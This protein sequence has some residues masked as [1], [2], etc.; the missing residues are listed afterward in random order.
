ME[1]LGRDQLLEWIST[2][3]QQQVDSLEA[4][5][6]G[7]LFLQVLDH[8]VP[9]A[10]LDQARMVS[11]PTTKREVLRNYSL[12][13]E[14]LSGST[15]LQGFSDLC[16]RGEV[17]GK[18]DCLQF[19]ALLYRHCQHVTRIKSGLANLKM[20]RRP[21]ARREAPEKRSPQEAPPVSPARSPR[22][23]VRL[24]TSP[25]ALGVHSWAPPTPTKACMSPA[26]QI[27][28]RMG[29][30]TDS[31]LS[32]GAQC[33]VHGLGPSEAEVAVL[34]ALCRGFLSRS[35][36]EKRLAIQEYGATAVQSVWRGHAVRQ[37]ARAARVRIAGKQ[38]QLAMLRA[39]EEQFA[40][41]QVQ[42]AREARAAQEE[43]SLRAEEAAVAAQEAR[44]QAA[45]QEAAEE[46]AAAAERDAVEAAAAATE[47]AAEEAAAQA[48]TAER[49][50]AQAV[51]EEAA[52]Q[53][54]AAEA[55]QAAEEAAAAEAA[56]AQ[57]AA[58]EAAAEEATRAQAAAEE[59]AAEEA[60]RAQAA[61]EEAAAE[62]AAQKAH[63]QA[64]AEEAAA[65]AAAQKAHAQ[66][67]AEEAAAEAA[68][69]KAQAQAAAEE[70]AAEAAAQKAQAQAAAEEA[71]AEAAAQKAQAQAA[72][73]EA[74]A[75][76][77]AA[78]AA[79]RTQAAAAEEAR[80]Q[81][82]AASALAAAEDTARAQARLRSKAVQLLSRALTRAQASAAMRHAF[83][84]YLVQWS[85]CRHKSSQLR[86]KATQ[87][88]NA[89]CF[90]RVQVHQLEALSCFK[91]NHASQGRSR[92]LEQAEKKRQ[93]HET[94]LGVHI[95]GP[96][97]QGLPQPA[98]SPAQSIRKHRQHGLDGSS[99]N[100]ANWRWSDDEASGYWPEFQTGQSVAEHISGRS[101]TKAAEPV[102]QS[103]L[104]AFFADE[105]ADDGSVPEVA[106]SPAQK[107]R[108]K[109]E[110]HPTNWPGSALAVEGNSSHSHS[111]HSSRP[112]TAQ[113]E[114]SYEA[115]SSP[116]LRTRQSGEHSRH[117]SRPGTAQGEQSYEAPS[118]PNLRT[119]QSGEH[120]RHS[121]RPGT[122]Q[123]E[124]S[125]EAPSSPNLRTR[126]SG[127][128]SRHSSRPGTAQGEQS[129]EAPAS[130]ADRIKAS[131][132]WQ[133][134]GAYDSDRYASKKQEEQAL[135][136]QLHPEFSAP[137]QL[138]HLTAAPRRRLMTPDLELQLQ[139]ID[140]RKLT[141]AAPLSSTD[142]LT[143]ALLL[144][145]QQIIQNE[146]DE[147]SSVME[148]RRQLGNMALQQLLN[149]GS[150]AG[151]LQASPAPTVQPPVS[152]SRLQP[153]QPRLQ[154]A[155][156]AR[157]VTNRST[158]D[159]FDIARTND[160]DLEPAAHN[161]S[162]VVE[163]SVISIPMDTVH[164]REP[165]LNSARK[166]ATDRPTECEAR[167]PPV[168][169]GSLDRSN[170][171][172]IRNALQHVCL[173]GPVKKPEL[174]DALGVLDARGNV[175]HYMVLFASDKNL[176]FRGLYELDAGMDVATKVHGVGP[177]TVQAGK[178]YKFFNYSS[179]SKSFGT[180]PTTT[181]GYTV[182]GFALA[183]SMRNK[184]TRPS[185]QNSK[186]KTMV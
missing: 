3:S 175:G 106:S 87:L 94:A 5:R 177:G 23:A 10:K 166:P 78:E 122:A 4:L 15:D 27:K 64:A 100:A 157:S 124:Q 47:E 56:R 103:T 114:Q 156:S 92:V 159:Q 34:Q 112:G 97:A 16:G 73:E 128:H 69:Q 113:G 2:Q 161:M 143:E 20:K 105:W 119:R 148:R 13:T 22:P 93:E 63:A 98:E 167:A 101:T 96:A 95:P 86:F 173:A 162:P 134:Q 18:R 91:H 155:P 107:I 89:C 66:A 76:A 14:M 53:A 68:A 121:S 33:S 28:E 90:A 110:E 160:S 99:P 80:R 9:A 127:E 150:K 176:V 141:P 65:E 79:A 37:Q 152:Q 111:R 131:S 117:S 46:A 85:R 59:A 184:G 104:T 61:A 183:P 129:Y 60:A 125:Y 102:R 181:Y 170:A 168:L 77:A 83:E 25:D 74:W 108:N 52:A 54:A 163:P 55:A 123:G 19:A 12:L 171:K 45:A 149:P 154:S 116:N 115:P 48:A 144:Q 120:S 88:V 136:P 62:A 153:L 17:M 140:V 138:Q 145:Q 132:S 42:E 70:A 58:E 165:R 31:P 75:A 44:A 130:P 36:V 182:Y 43:A 164:K 39:E 81:A 50:A 11:N 118:S 185:S 49:A 147:K 126:Q 179:G 26:Q 7:T 41:Q 84:R 133:V 51:A 186:M 169:K 142:S 180:I 57:A 137:P 72:A 172:M 30:P 32:N 82:E 29:R 146:A 151:Q 67:A 40:L 8:A 1:S 158:R 21:A 139:S 178:V 38:H 109:W 24:D 6:S 71:A 35:E 174:A 135:S